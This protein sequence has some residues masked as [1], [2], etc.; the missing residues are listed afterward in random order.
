MILKLNGGLQNVPD[1]SDT[2]VEMELVLEEL[3][4]VYGRDSILL[5]VLDLGQLRHR[6]HNVFDVL[7]GDNLTFVREC[8]GKIRRSGLKILGRNF[9][10]QNRKSYFVLQRA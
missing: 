3:L 2:K 1:I 4:P 8:R 6:Q 9:G 5:L 7:L 10:V